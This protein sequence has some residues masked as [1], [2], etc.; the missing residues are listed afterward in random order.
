MSSS[1]PSLTVGYGTLHVQDKCCVISPKLPFNLQKTTVRRVLEPETMFLYF[2][3]TMFF[4]FPSL[5]R[6]CPIAFLN[7][8]QLF[9]WG[10]CCK[11]CP[12]LLLFISAEPAGFICNPL[13]LSIGG[14]KKRNK[15]FPLSASRLYFLSAT[16]FLPQRLFL[17]ANGYAEVQD[18]L[19]TFLCNFSSYT[20]KQRELGVRTGFWMG[21]IFSSLSKIYLTHHM[22]F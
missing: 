3:A 12:Q 21:L 18:L 20:Q 16:S 14:G 2:Q 8:C 4:I 11:L 13:N 1:Q 19:Y 10:A 7:S 22:Y 5:Q 9:T 17:C 6:N 15:L